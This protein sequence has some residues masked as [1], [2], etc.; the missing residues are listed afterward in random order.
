[1][2]SAFMPSDMEA[3]PY[4]LVAADVGARP[5]NT[6]RRIK[7]AAISFAA[8]AAIAFLIPHRT[9]NGPFEAARSVNELSSFRDRMSIGKFQGCRFDNDTLKC[10]TSR[11]RSR[12]SSSWIVRR[13]VLQQIARPIM[14]MQ[15]RDRPR[16]LSVRPPKGSEPL[17]PNRLRRA[18]RPQRRQPGGRRRR[19]A[20]ARSRPRPWRLWSCTRRRA[21]SSQCR[22]LTR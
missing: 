16:H 19:L 3:T 17:R 11:R 20:A 22:S 6:Y 10:K 14:Q 12:C 1:M 13:S 18:A 4:T 2:A 7:L 21:K 9:P 5:Q 15:Q 8:V